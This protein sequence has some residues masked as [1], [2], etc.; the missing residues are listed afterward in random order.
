MP[1]TLSAAE[2]NAAVRERQL[3]VE[4]IVRSCLERTAA[5]NPVLNAVCTLCPEAA[6]AASRESDARIAKGDPIRPLDGVP[7]LV[8]DNIPTAG[9]RTTFG[10]RVFEHHVPAEDSLDVQRMKAAG[11]ILLGKT[12]TP[13]FAHEPTTSNLIF[14]VTRNPWNVRRSAGGSSGGNGS[15]LAAGMAP[16][17]IGTDMGGSV[18]IP[19]AFCGITA[20]RPA[21]GRIPI[22]PTDFGWDTLVHHVRGPMARTVLDLGILLS[23]MAGPDDRDPSSL[24]LDGLDFKGAATGQMSLSGAT[25][26]YSRALGGVAPVDPIVSRAVESILPKL[27][28]R[29]FTIEEAD[30]DISEIKRI[31]RP[32]RAFAILARWGSL[33]HSHRELLTTSIIHQIDDALSF[34]VMDITEA[35]RLRTALWHR[36]RRFMQRFDFIITPT[37]GVTAFPLDE[38]LPSTIAGRPVENYYDA[39]LFTYAFSLAGLPSLSIPCGMSPDG[40][41]IGL[42]IVG[43]RLREDKVLALGAILE[44]LVPKMGWPIVAMACTPSDSEL[45]YD[46]GFRM[47]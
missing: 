46:H 16:A 14:G 34:T 38:P 6:L 40:L 28:D 41:P 13:E 11:A 5:T 8:K 9:L 25:I 23:V 4:Q 21:P 44:T 39:I 30:P 47:T 19:A 35:E 33:L 24:P 18:R 26:A 29:G 27:S 12:N 32:T 2:L 10:S 31:I 37:V 45:S 17:A 42:Q 20:I 36:I 22:Y 3:S 15:A 43:P 1:W 7:F